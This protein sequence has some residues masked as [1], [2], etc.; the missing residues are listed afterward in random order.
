MNTAGGQ[1]QPRQ[2]RYI[3]LGAEVEVV[4]GRGRGAVAVG[5]AVDGIGQFAVDVHHATEQAKALERFAEQAQLDAPVLALTVRAEYPRAGVGLVGRLLDAEGAGG[6]G[7][8]AQ[9][10]LG[11][12][13]DLAADERREDL[14]VVDRGRRGDLA[15]AQAFHVVG[16]ERQLVGE[17]V[18]D[19]R[20]WR[21]LLLVVGRVTLDVIVPV[22]DLDPLPAGA[23]GQQQ[24]VIDKAEGVGQRHAAEAVLGVDLGVDASGRDGCRSLQRIVE[25][26]GG[27]TVTRTTIGEVHVEITGGQVQLMAHRAGV[28]PVAQARHGGPDRLVAGKITGLDA[29]VASIVDDGDV[30]PEEVMVALASADRGIGQQRIAEVELA[31]QRAEGILGTRLAPGLR[32]VV[33]HLV[34]IRHP[35]IGTHQ[36]PFLRGIGIAL[37]M[38]EIR[39][40]PQPL[41]AKIQAQHGHLAVD[42]LVVPLGIAGLL[43]AVETQAELVLVTETA[44]DI[45]HPADLAVR[46]VAAGE[47]GERLVARALGHQVD[48]AA[49]A[50]PRRDAVDQ[51]ARALE[52]VHPLGHFH[53]DRIGRQDAVQAVVG[54]VAVEQTEAADGELLEAP[55]GRVG[56]AH[57]RIAADQVAQGARLLVLHG[58]AGVG[59]HAER[60]LHEIPI[61][62]HAQ[63]AAATH[64]AA[65]IGLCGF[66]GADDHGRRQ[67]VRVGG[68]RRGG[69]ER[70]GLLAHGPQL[71]PGTLQQLGEALLDR[72]FAGQPGAV[73]ALHQRRIQRQIDPGQAGE[74]GQRGAQATG[75]HLVTAADGILGPTGRD[76]QGADTQAQQQTQAQQGAHR[77]QTERQDYGH[78]RGSLLSFTCL[79]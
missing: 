13:L 3:P 49:D 54:N 25:V 37:G 68:R 59:G 70:I 60:G 31:A 2:G 46:G 66:P 7:E 26:A 8:R 22:I 40:K 75:R 48:A 72:V 20:R 5:G 71:Q 61:T 51:L 74:A 76:E 53:V 56:G 23:Q 30:M 34:R 28:E 14:V 11:A 67:L 77:A 55:A 42:A 69:R 18:Q 15:L 16:V 36:H 4:L 19:A 6:E 9:V 50:A 33:T 79:E 12:D 62:E 44:A 10:I 64:L 39:R 29:E 47:L 57:R 78:W 27:R 65:G 21:D 73:A 1:G 52:D 63:G 35:G 17:L 45:Q 24:A 43:H 58:V 38:P 41:S 32:I